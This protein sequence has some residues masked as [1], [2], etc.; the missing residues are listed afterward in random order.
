MIT[1]MMTTMTMTMM[2]II[3]C[4]FSINAQVIIEMRML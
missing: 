3:I 2:I 1:T 4:V